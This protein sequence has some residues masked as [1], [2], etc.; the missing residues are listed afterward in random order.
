MLNDRAG[1]CPSILHFAAAVT[2]PVRDAGGWPDG[3]FQGT[4]VVC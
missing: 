3:K 4:H 2:A 1:S